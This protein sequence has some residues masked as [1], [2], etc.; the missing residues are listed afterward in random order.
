MIT[1]TATEASPF[2]GASPK[3]RHYNSTNPFRERSRHE[4]LLSIN[5]SP[6][7]YYDLGL[8]YAF[9]SQSQR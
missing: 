7:L 8:T 5:R 1:L 4:P 2:L 9:L 3:P 6:L